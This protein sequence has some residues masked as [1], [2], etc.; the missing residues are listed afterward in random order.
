MTTWEEFKKAVEAEGVLNTDTIDY[1][2]W[3]G[4]FVCSLVRVEREVYPN[5]EVG[6]KIT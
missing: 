5:G 4:G 1:I 6:V 2:D 3:A